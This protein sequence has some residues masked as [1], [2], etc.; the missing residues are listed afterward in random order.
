[1][2]L[3]DGLYSVF[4]KRTTLYVPVMLVGAY[5]TNNVIDAG[6]DAFWATKNKGKSFQEMLQQVQ[7]AS[8]GSE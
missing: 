6:I 5:Y 3:W 2:S 1:M 7:A 8:P 4:W